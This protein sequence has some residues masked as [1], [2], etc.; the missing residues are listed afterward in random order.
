[1]KTFDEVKQELAALGTKAALDLLQA[2][3]QYPESTYSQVSKALCGKENSTPDEVLKAVDQLK[4]RVNQLEYA[5]L[6]M[7]SQYCVEPDGTVT[8]LFMS[9]GEHAFEALGIGNYESEENLEL[10]IE[11]LETAQ[12]K[13]D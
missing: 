6:L 7:V 2:A 9:A 1:M 3:E 13:T 12:K 10:M 5:L 4:K 11:R 8:H